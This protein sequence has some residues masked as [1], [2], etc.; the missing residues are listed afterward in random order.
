MTR[1]EPV[2]SYRSK[3]WQ[4]SLFSLFVVTT[5]SAFSV[6]YAVYLLRREPTL[7]VS[8]VALQA[9]NGQ[10]W[11]MTYGT[12]IGTLHF[13]V[14]ERLSG[15]SAVRL[16]HSIETGSTAVLHCQDGSEI[17]LTNARGVLLYEPLRDGVT[18]V[19]E[20]SLTLGNLQRF[21]ASNRERYD[22]ASLVTYSR[23][24]VG[25]LSREIPA[26]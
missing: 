4:F 26:R 16:S 21:V 17:A 23:A 11:C 13:V 22:V 6:C 10:H 5:I 24:T 2:R 19:R 20:D 8:V 14:C 1:P 15:P 25:K 12:R 18:I 9:H 7:E 3:N